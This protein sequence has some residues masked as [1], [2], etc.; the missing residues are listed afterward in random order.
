[1]DSE[2]S[3]S[4]RSERE[5]WKVMQSRIEPE[6][7]VQLLWEFQTVSIPITDHSHSKKK[8]MNPRDKSSNLPTNYKITSLLLFLIF[9]IMYIL[10]ARIS[11]PNFNTPFLNSLGCV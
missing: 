10:L 7:M 1:M 11:S 3:S 6:A 9:I 2:S 4:W 5:D 8:M